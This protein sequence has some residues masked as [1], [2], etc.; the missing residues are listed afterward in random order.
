[1]AQFVS[2]CLRTMALVLGRRNQNDEDSSTS[3][4]LQYLNDFI[5][6]SMSHDIRLL[7]QFATMQFTIGVIPVGSTPGLYNIS[8]LGLD[9]TFVS[10][11]NEAMISI[12]DTV[13]SSTSWSRLEVYMD[14]SIF[15]NKWGINNED[16]L[17][18]GYPQ[19]MLFYQNQ[20][21]FRPVPD[22]DYLVQIYS[23]KRSGAFDSAGNPELQFDYMMRYYAYGAALNYA[24][25]FRY[26]QEALKNIYD[27][28]TYERKLLLT[29][30]HNQIKIN[31]A[32]PRF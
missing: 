17:T 16:I 32:I 19:D 14:P 29:R 3:I 28:Y 4:F 15:F 26:G 18:P 2:D 11:G 31:Q 20:L 21:I 9:S 24:R 10:I 12:K 27:G 1:M 13:G 30:Q 7:E 23:Y 8:D 5:T 22:K 6:L 25:D